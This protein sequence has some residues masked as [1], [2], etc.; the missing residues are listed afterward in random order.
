MA[1][2]V[3]AQYV[4]EPLPAG[5][6]AA[7]VIQAPEIKDRKA[8]TNR[9]PAHQSTK[10]ADSSNAISSTSN[11]PSNDS[12]D[13]SETSDVDPIPTT[14]RS[15][16]I[17]FYDEREI[18]EQEHDIC[19]AS[20]TRRKFERTIH[21][22]QQQNSELIETVDNLSLE[23]QAR[24]TMKKW[25]EV[26]QQLQESEEKISDLL[27]YRKEELSL[28]SWRRK[29]PTAERIKIDKKNHD[30]GIWLMESLPKTTLVET[31]QLICREL[32]LSNV[33]DLHP[34]LK[35][36]KAVVRVV[37]QMEK[38]LSKILI[39]LGDRNKI[40]LEQLRI[41]DIDDDGLFSIT[42]IMPTL[43]R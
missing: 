4:H 42:H 43:E 29:L 7:K 14:D 33:A 31:V 22:L 16:Q 37:P 6:K 17:L 30:L 41:G 12:R 19:S 39:F 34:S 13:I 2:L 9:I 10:N 24:P 36:L 35:K 32:D 27:T 40:L 26:L 18:G 25:R 5:G 1:P 23:L 15:G 20:D 21:L 38:V 3:T 11:F 28:E 8:P